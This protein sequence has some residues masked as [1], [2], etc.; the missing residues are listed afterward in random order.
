MFFLVGGVIQRAILGH[1]PGG[2]STWWSLLGLPSWCPLVNSSHCNSF[3]DRA[4]VDFIY[5]CPIFKWAAE[6]WSHDR[7]TAQW[8]QKWPPGQTPHVSQHQATIQVSTA[9]CT[10][11]CLLWWSL[12]SHLLWRSSCVIPDELYMCDCRPVGQRKRQRSEA[13]EKKISTNWIS[14]I[15]SH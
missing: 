4:P 6:T 7:G 8:P 15:K 14:I 9:W 10:S 5:G 12:S 1:I 13:L 3:E 2:M 11:L